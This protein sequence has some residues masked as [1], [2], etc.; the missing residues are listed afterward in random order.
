MIMHIASLAKAFL[1][2]LACG[3]RAW[4]KHRKKV[5]TTVLCIMYL[6]EGKG[7]RIPREDSAL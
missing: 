5:Y 2:G 4:V 1:R 6:S 7:K 3:V